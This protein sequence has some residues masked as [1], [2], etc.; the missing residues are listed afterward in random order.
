MDVNGN[1]SISRT[2]RFP[3][4]QEMHRDVRLL[5]ADRA[6]QG[7][8]VQPLVDALTERKVQAEPGQRAFELSQ[9]K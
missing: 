7:K 6:F 9:R 2:G 8:Q 5:N 1:K 4:K 3:P